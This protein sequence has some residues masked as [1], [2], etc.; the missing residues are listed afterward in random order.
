V[1]EGVRRWE[2]R[3]R[4]QGVGALFDVELDALGVPTR[5]LLR[6]V[7]WRPPERIAWVSES[8]PVAQRGGWIFRPVPGGVEVELQIGYEL[9]RLPLASLVAGAADAS[10]RRRLEAA[11]DRMRDL[12]EA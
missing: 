1:L 10:L 5:S 3:G 6:I 7:E 4:A 2:P 8:G 11:L 12:L 9:P